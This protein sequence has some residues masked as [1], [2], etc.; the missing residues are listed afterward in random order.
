MLI[1][2]SDHKHQRPSE[3]TVSRGSVWFNDASP[4]Y[5]SDSAFGKSNRKLLLLEHRSTEMKVCETNVN[6]WTLSEELI[7]YVIEEQRNECRSILGAFSLLEIVT[8]TNDLHYLSVSVHSWR[9]VM[10]DR[11][12]ERICGGYLYKPYGYRPDEIFLYCGAFFNK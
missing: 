9:T 11:K 5:I 10:N 2:R 12:V 6:K 7:S 8:T 4:W 1:T 3:L